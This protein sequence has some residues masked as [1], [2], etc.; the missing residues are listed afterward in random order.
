MKNITDN[1]IRRKKKKFKKKEVCGKQKSVCL[2]HVCSQ[3]LEVELSMEYGKE[4]RSSPKLCNT[5]VQT[6][7]DSSSHLIED[8]K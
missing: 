6:I 7:N 5:T 8:N 3:V 1:R 4:R 2:G